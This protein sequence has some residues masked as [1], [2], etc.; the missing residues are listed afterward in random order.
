[1][2][3]SISNTVNISVF[4][5]TINSEIIQTVNA[6][7]LHQFIE[8]QD[9]IRF[10][11]KMKANN[12]TVIEY[13]ISIDMAKKLAMVERNTNGKEARQYFTSNSQF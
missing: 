10:H 6:R 3:N 1:M 5:S 8:N 4:E 2:T 12:A 7:D 11:K 13:H 9:F